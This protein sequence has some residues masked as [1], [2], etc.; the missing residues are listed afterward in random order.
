MIQE[1][2]LDEPELIDRILNGEKSLYE[3]IIRHYNPYLYK[4]GRSYNYSHEDTE[5]LMQDTFVDAYKGLQQF[6]GRAQFKTWVT[7]IMMN[8]CY[9]KKRKLSYKNEVMREVDDQSKP[10]FADMSGD[11]RKVVH[12]H[13][14]KHIIED[15]LG[16]I[17]FKYRIVFS[18]REINGMNVEETAELVDISRSNVKVRLNRAKKMLRNYIKRSYKPSELFDFNLIYCDSIVNNVME[19]INKL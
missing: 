19:R 8:N 12:T 9:R 4:I 13:E 2:E 18:L 17:P 16:Q 11:T 3:Q 6:E 15:A 10:L 5:D 7:R 14:L 1:K